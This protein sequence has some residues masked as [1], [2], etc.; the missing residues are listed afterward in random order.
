MQMQLK[1]AVQPILEEYNSQQR[2]LNL[3]EVWQTSQR[4]ESRKALDIPP[5][6]CYEASKRVVV[7]RTGQSM[8]YVL[9]EVSWGSALGVLPQVGERQ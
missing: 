5:K 3:P 9:H 8:P 4:S 2:L 6:L 1:A 7:E